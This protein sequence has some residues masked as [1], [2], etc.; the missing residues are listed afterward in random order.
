[1][2]A[3]ELIKHCEALEQATRSTL[4]PCRNA[5]QYAMESL[6]QALSNELAKR[7]KDA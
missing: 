7:N 3:S 1:M 2:G 4:E 5:V 6:E